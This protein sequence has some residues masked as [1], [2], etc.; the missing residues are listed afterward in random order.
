MKVSA[1]TIPTTAS[2]EKSIF[3]VIADLTKARLTS[4]VLLTT[5]VGFYAGSTT[6]VD[7]AVMIHAMLG[8]ALV[9]CGASALNQLLERDLDRKMR[10]TENRPLPSG[11][12]SP[13]V[14]LMTGAAL[15]AAGLVYLALAVNYLTSFLGAATLASYVFVYTPLKR[16]TT[17][18]TV[19]GAIPGAIPP[20]MG[21][22]AARGEVTIGGWSLFAI[23]FFW[24][25]PH[26][27][28]IAWL[29]REDYARGGF[30]MLPVLDREGRRTGSVAIS[31]ALGLIPISLCPSLFGMS[32]IIYFLGAL[33][34]GA[35]FLIYAIQ[36]ARHMTE[37]KARQLFFASIVYLPLLLSLL[38]LDKVK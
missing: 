9:A 16:K 15:S 21:W 31:Y 1:P 33:L 4:L 37:H 6:S 7:V 29:Y 18:N 32:G 10:R 12:L 11:R 20:L 13:D 3:S 26:F 27:M 14:V 25:L 36:F 35:A 8:T 17:L 34:L 19:I 30:A 5:L 24:Q 22:T 2:A 28:S 38:V 23:L